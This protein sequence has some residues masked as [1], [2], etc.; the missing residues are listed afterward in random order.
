MDEITRERSKSFI[1]QAKMKTEKTSQETASAIKMLSEVYS[2]YATV[3]VDLLETKS[4]YISIVEKY[5]DANPVASVGHYFPGIQQSNSQFSNTEMEVDS[6]EM[7]RMA[8][9]VRDLEYQKDSLEDQLERIF[10]KT[11]GNI[12]E[13]EALSMQTSTYLDNLIEDVGE[14]YGSSTMNQLIQRNSV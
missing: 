14:V 5:L 13:I 9:L 6:T 4:K 10:K 2:Q 7:N 3:V 8:E 12:H 11:V 1:D